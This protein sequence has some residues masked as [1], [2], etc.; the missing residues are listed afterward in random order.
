MSRSKNHG[1]GKGGGC[2]LCRPHKKWKSNS[3]K[4]QKPSV[5]RQVQKGKEQR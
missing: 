2:S 4:D 5:Q 3:V 1:C